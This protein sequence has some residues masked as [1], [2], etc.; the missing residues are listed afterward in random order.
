MAHK[1]FD[2]VIPAAEKGGRPRRVRV[3][4]RNE[5]NARRR[6]EKYGKVVAFIMEDGS[7]R[8]WASVG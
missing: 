2:F 4:A 3:R 1:S 7:E 5:A 8:P 6:I